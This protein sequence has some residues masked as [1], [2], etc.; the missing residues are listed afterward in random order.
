M[1]EEALQT[2]E[3]DTPPVPTFSFQKGPSAA[4]KAAKASKNDDSP[5]P[6]TEGVV[7]LDS[8]PSPDKAESK[9]QRQTRSSRASVARDYEP[10]HYSYLSTK[11]RRTVQDALTELSHI[12]SKSGHEVRTIKLFIEEAVT[13]WKNSPL[14]KIECRDSASHVTV[15]SK[16]DP[17]DTFNNQI[18]YSLKLFLKDVC[19]E[20]GKVGHPVSTI[21]AIL[22]EAFLL[23]LPRQSDLPKECLDEVRKARDL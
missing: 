20:R 8:N 17:L 10:K 12:R 19:H 13:L 22:D 21:I 15:R 4:P 1:T 7:V 2:A 11:V 3:D 23:W 16:D 9:K 5:K 18:E 6:E 14:A